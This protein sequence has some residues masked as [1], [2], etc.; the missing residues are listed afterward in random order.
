MLNISLTLINK[1][2]PAVFKPKGIILRVFPTFVE[3]FY[4]PNPC[5]TI[6]DAFVETKNILTF[7]LGLS[8]THKKT[9]HSEEKWLV[10]SI[11][12]LKVQ[13]RIIFFTIFKYSTLRHENDTEAD[14]HDSNRWL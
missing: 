10:F 11:Y 9:I 2:Q 1:L 12:Q 6:K 14:C 7:Y 13:K 8:K 4:N 5:P 3:S